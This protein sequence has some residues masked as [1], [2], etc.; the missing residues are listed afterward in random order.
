MSCS[1]FDL[2]DFF[3]KELPEPQRLAVEAH[4]RKCP[5]CRE[6]LDRLQL[7]ETA[8]FALRDEEIPRRVAFVSDPVFE[9]PA[10]RRW[11]ASFWGSPARL[12]FAGAALLSAAILVSALTRPAAPTLVSPVAQAPAQTQTA[13]IT[14]EDMDRQIRAAVEQAVRESESRQALKTDATLAS[15][16]ER[17]QQE[18]RQLKY[19]EELNRNMDRRFGALSAANYRTQSGNLGEEK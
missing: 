3:L 11:W 18:R 17:E 8:L 15:F 4:T 12:G 7:T 1:P 5:A 16:V 19:A 2:K 9:A 6:E 14:K 10:A 13:S